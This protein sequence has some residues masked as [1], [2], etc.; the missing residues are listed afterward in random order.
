VLGA[1]SVRYCAGQPCSGRVE[2][3]Y[4]NGSLMHSGTYV[5]GM[6]V[7][8][9][10]YHANGALE[11]EFREIDAIKSIMRTY[12][13]NGN[14]RSEVRYA[15]G[16]S[17][18][19]EDHYANG[20][21]RYVE[22]RHRSEPYY[23]RMDLFASNGDPISL[24]KLVD[25]KQVEFELKEYYPG[26]KLNSEGRARYNEQRM[27]TQRVGTWRYFD[28]EGRLLREEDYVDGKVHAVR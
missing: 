15:E 23:L 27:D 8:Y 4:V 6:L 12:H 9:K 13:A 25:R 17:Y 22:E 26:G 20:A 24:L 18:Q 16:V 14:L 10:N 19:Y 11:R 21:L 1:D 2:D 7:F 3:R 5:D 28:K